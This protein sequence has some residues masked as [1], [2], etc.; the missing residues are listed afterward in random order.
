MTNNL[1]LVFFSL[2]LSFFVQI[3]TKTELDIE[4]I[5]A[6]ILTNHNYHRIRHQ[7][8]GLERDVEIESVAQSYS[9]YLA[10]IDDMKHSTDHPEYGE[11]LFMCG[12]SYG[13][14]VTG[15]YASESWYEEVSLYDFNN[16]GYVSGAGHFTQLVWK[17]SKKIGCGASCN[18][19]N[20]CYVTCNY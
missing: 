17:S 14:C 4:K 7:V 3:K 19:N 12:S 20:N 11:N 9:E 8:D 13:I 16:P 10:E 5:R 2:I 18:N 15:E 6:D 1:Y